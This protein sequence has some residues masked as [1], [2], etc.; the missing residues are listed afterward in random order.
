MSEQAAE[1]FELA[2]HRMEQKHD[3]PLTAQTRADRAIRIPWADI[4]QMILDEICTNTIGSYHFRPLM[5]SYR[6]DA[7]TLL[8]WG[9][10]VSLIQE[11][12]HTY[13]DGWEGIGSKDSVHKYWD[14]L[15]HDEKKAISK[16][17][18]DRTGGVSYASAKLLINQEPL[19]DLLATVTHDIPKEAFKNNTFKKKWCKEGLDKLLYTHTFV[20]D[21]QATLA[22]KEA[23]ISK[24]KKLVEEQSDT[25]SSKQTR[26]QKKRKRETRKRGG[27]KSKKD[28]TEDPVP[29]A[30][31]EDD[32]ED[33]SVS[34][35]TETQDLKGTTACKACLAEGLGPVWHKGPCNKGLREKAKI[36]F[37]KRAGDRFW[38]SY[39]YKLIKPNKRKFTHHDYNMDHCGWCIAA[40]IDPQFAK[41]H[42]P[43]RCFRRK[44][45]P[46]QV[47]LGVNYKTM[48]CNSYK[49]DI[50]NARAQAMREYRKKVM[51][52]KKKSKKKKGKEARENQATEKFAFK[53]P[54]TDHRRG[55]EHLTL[56]LKE[57]RYVAIMSYP[58][59]FSDLEVLEDLRSHYF[60]DPG[61]VI[62]LRAKIKDL[63]KAERDRIGKLIEETD[64]P[65]LRHIPHV[66]A[67]A[68]RKRAKSTSDALAAAEPEEESEDPDEFLVE[69]GNAYPTPECYATGFMSHADM[70][71]MNRRL[72]AELADQMEFNRL[73]EKWS[74]DHP[75]E[76]FAISKLDPVGKALAMKVKAAHEYD[77]SFN[78]AVKKERAEQ[79]RLKESALKS[80]ADTDASEVGQP[81]QSSV[82]TRTQCT[83][84]VPICHQPT[85]PSTGGSERPRIGLVD[86]IRLRLKESPSRHFHLPTEA[87]IPAVKTSLPIARTNFD[88]A[89][90]NSIDSI[91]NTSRGPLRTEQKGYRMLQAYM[92][93]RDAK[94]E[95]RVG[96]VQLDTQSQVNFAL[97]G[98]SLV[99]DW[100]PWESKYCLGMKREV[101][102][103]KQPTT[104]TVMREGTP[105][106]IDTNDPHAGRLNSDCIALLGLEAIQKLGIDLNYHARFAAHK[107]VK[108]LDTVESVIERCEDE[109]RETLQ[110][111]AAPLSA[112]DLCRESHL[113]ERVIQ[114]YLEKHPNEYESKDIPLESIDICPDLGEK[115]TEAIL[116]LIREFRDVFATKSN[117]LPPTMK[118]VKPHSFKFKPGAE[119]TTV[120]PPKFGPAKAKL[121]MEW[122][123]WALDND[124]VEEAPGSAYSSRLHLAAKYKATTPKSEPPDGIRITWAGVEVN[125]TILK[126]VST[127]TDAW[128][129]LYKVAHLKYK[130]SADGLK[131]YW[132]I[133]L[134]K[135]SRDATAFWTPRGLFRFKRLVMGTKNAATIAQNAYTNALHT[136]LAKESQDSIANFADDF[137]G[138]GDTPAILIKNFRNFLKMARA[139]GITINPEKVRVDYTS[140]TFFGLLVKEGKISNS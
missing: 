97:S 98:V 53:L 128:E 13:G 139:A 1:Y 92:H 44:D 106:I 64:W 52:S 126:S 18:R 138:G 51:D 54:T 11:G 68:G 101:V 57:L 77:A 75:G 81:A 38:M 31:F 99:R 3:P 93:Y 61:K 85:V 102:P 76:T 111:Y 80:D 65:K 41:G 107:P 60:K 109:L 120:P 71:A 33:A 8:K 95:V 79:K 15:S 16:F 2:I 122:L 114:G 39:G 117:T 110:E 19:K 6:P 55:L 74:T 56:T 136:K 36:A 43:A 125:E 69:H 26:R 131:Q 40:D 104:F 32:D 21:L 22:K 5:T 108:Y 7:Q 132:S 135:D 46:I 140:E 4:R 48:I 86:R 127:Y 100:Q 91:N 27:G 84:S 113:S 9:Q 73:K 103:L 134:D 34:F 133:P 23:E 88:N 25:G 35:S 67:S 66:T 49:K 115:F 47:I 118:D 96:R 59:T 42:D 123:Q 94:G 10:R 28:K 130:F 119:P 45:G 29:D 90:T 14:W 30:E 70:V 83:S 124:L 121:I 37:T 72:R 24:L 17:Y 63:D 87:W 105:V 62:G 12:I 116:D 78:K 112:Q 50:A 89:N 82:G 137:L 129:Q 20:A 58:E